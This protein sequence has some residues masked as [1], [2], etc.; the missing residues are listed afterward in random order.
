[1]KPLVM[2]HILARNQEQMLPLYLECIEKQDYPKDRIVL[3][4]KTNNNSDDTETILKDWLNV[5][6]EQYHGRV[7]ESY[8]SH[9]LTENPNHLWDGAR[10]DLM[11]HLRD[12]GFMMAREYSCDFYFTADVD[13]FIIPST[14]SD[15][16]DLNLPVVAPMLRWAIGDESETEHLPELL[17]RGADYTAANFTTKVTDWGDTQSNSPGG[18][19]RFP[20]GYFNILYRKNIGVLPAELVHCTYLVHK[21]VFNRISYQNGVAGG[22][23]Y[24]TFAFNLRINGIPQFIDNRKLYGC[25]TMAETADTARA[26]MNKILAGETPEQWIEKIK[27]LDRSHTPFGPQ[28]ANFESFVKDVQNYVN[29]L[30]IKNVYDIGACNGNES[31]H[32]MHIFP[33]AL[34]RSFEPNPDNFEVLLEN[35]SPYW[36]RIIPYKVA[37]SDYLGTA[38][39]YDLEYM[40]G[41]SSLLAP[42]AEESPFD[43]THREIEVYVDRFDNFEFDVADAVIWMDVQGNE[44]NTLK[45]FGEELKKVAVIYTEVGL[46]AYYEGHTLIDEITTYLHGHGFVLAKFYT[47]WEKEANVMFVRADLIQQENNQQLHPK[48]E[49]SANS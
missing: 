14:I 34:V 27:P 38:K 24:I 1:M 18:E 12:K 32:L 37:L 17:K 19:E 4:I 31:V 33:N 22:Y 30:E 16:V 9:I 36:D 47:F 28:D 48:E 41:S 8:P 39:F 5:V 29:P 20:E 42:I 6:G 45:G 23:E 13:N 2:V 46:R 26:Y 35:I 15:L 49:T 3:Y 10:V 44:L 43:T 40:S 21:D 25:L 11:R 7:W